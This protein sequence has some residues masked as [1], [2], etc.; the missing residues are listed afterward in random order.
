ML[1]VPRIG[2][3]LL[4]VQRVPGKRVAVGHRHEEHAPSL[5]R[6]C[7]ASSAGLGNGRFSSTSAIE[8]I[9]G[10][11]TTNGFGKD[12]ACTECTQIQYTE[13]ARFEYHPNNALNPV[14]LGLLGV[15]TEN[16]EPVPHASG[17]AM[18]CRFLF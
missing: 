13:R 3:A 8:I 4:L 14:M 18:S 5:S 6:P 7:A 10:F 16:C 2:I 12:S 17:Y 9:F 11:P 1:D 15:E